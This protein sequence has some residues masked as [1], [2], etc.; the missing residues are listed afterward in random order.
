MPSK[1][2]AGETVDKNEFESLDHYYKNLFI[3]EMKTGNY[4]GPMNPR[5][6][7]NEDTG[8]LWLLD[9]QFNANYLNNQIQGYAFGLHEFWFKQIVEK[10]AC[11]DVTLGESIDYIRYLYR[12]LSISYLFESIKINHNLAAGLGAGKNICSISYQNLF[13][14][15]RPESLDMKKFHERVYGKFA[16]EIS[17][18]KATSFNKMEL[19][20]WLDNFHH[21]TALSLDPAST[22]LHEWCYSQ[23]KN[24]RDLSV[25]D[26]KLALESICNEESALIQNICSEQDNLYG[27]SYI[28]KAAELIQSS[29]AFK[30]IDN[31]G[32][33]EN[34]L[35]RYSKIFTPKEIHYGF[36]GHQFPL[37]YSELVRKNSRYLQ[38]DLFLPGALK[39]FDMKG[40][41]DFLAALKPPTVEP[42]IKALPIPKPKPRPIPKPV[43]VEVK[44]VDVPAP[45]PPAVVEV[46]APPEPKVSIF[47]KAVLELEGKM[48]D[49][50]LI[51]MVIFR[52]DFEFTPQMVAALAAP[53]KKF[54]TR[55]ALM[56]MKSYDNLGSFESPVGLIFLKYLL[57][58]ENHQGLY[59]IINVLGEKFYVNNDIEKMNHPVF[60]ELRNNQST[61]N[62]WQIVL[63]KKPGQL[64]KK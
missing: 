41:S 31:N 64:P 32:T 26:V 56:D 22:H 45:A 40:L 19:S 34:C 5:A 15:C 62:H 23:K 38:G 7:F 4:S 60:I 21:S 48:L 18:I 2:M 35:R 10:S 29:N 50:L 39:E 13:G 33:G 24:C 20:N 57:D 36:L 28:E 61:N 51:N 11:P 55:A 44:H 12:L 59:N 16:N 27:A 53:I 3:G 49:S 43:V 9:D 52:D 54:Q 6:N 63:L 25:E 30:L 46:V 58:A 17:K 1:I 37:I 42:V 14:K 8:S 47:E